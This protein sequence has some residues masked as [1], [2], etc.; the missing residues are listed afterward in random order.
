MGECGLTVWVLIAAAASCMHFCDDSRRLFVGMENGHITEFLVADD[1]NRM[2]QVRGYA[3]HQARVAQVVFSP[4][5]QWLLS[6]AKDKFLFIH[7]TESGR[8]LV[9]YPESGV[10]TSLQYDVQ[11]KTAFVGDDKG[12]ILM[13]KH[14]GQNLKLMTTLKGHLSAI[15]CLKWDPNRQMLFSGS[16]DQS[17]VCWDIGGKK[18]TTYELQGHK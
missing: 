13:L 4:A 18:G 15:L 16:Y 8:R 5:T 14:D 7:D 3:A 2:S 17:I 1:Y 10:C 12:Q 6:V 11:S 9:G